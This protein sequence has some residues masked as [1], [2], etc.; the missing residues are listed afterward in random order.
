MWVLRWTPFSAG[1]AVALT[2]PCLLSQ[3][4]A[5]W[6]RCCWTLCPCWETSCCSVSLSFSFSALLEF[7]CG[8]ASSETAASSKTT[9]PCEFP[10]L[11]V[12]FQ[13]D[14][15]CSP[16]GRV[17]VKSFHHPS[18]EGAFIRKQ[19]LISNS[20]IYLIALFTTLNSVTLLTW[21]YFSVQL[22][23]PCSLM[24][25][26]AF[27]GKFICIWRLIFRSPAFVS[28]MNHM[29][30]HMVILADSIG[31][32]CWLQVNVTC[33][34]VFR[35]RRVQPE[36]CCQTKVGLEGHWGRCGTALH[37]WMTENNGP[38]RASAAPILFLKHG[39]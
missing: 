16:C 10:C 27:S 26:L 20:Y 8:P 1:P 25:R 29:T 36:H 34:Q 19:L 15:S 7:S 13:T 30:C 33:N 14:R 4:C 3:V 9:S 23:F 18:D 32:H 35:R 6:W 28:S 38:E 11:P 17:A 5:S 2:C 37:W 21:F 31:A 39:L 12:L 22:L 24:F